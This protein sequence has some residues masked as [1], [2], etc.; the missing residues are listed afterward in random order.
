MCWAIRSLIETV[1]SVDKITDEFG[2]E[3]RGLVIIDTVTPQIATQTHAIAANLETIRSLT[4]ALQS[5][6]HSVIPQLDVFIH[7]LVDLAQAFDN[8]KNDDF[9]FLPPDALNTPDF[10]VGMD[11][12]MTADGKGA[13]IIVYHQGEAMS[14]EGIKQIQNV[15]TAAQESLKGTPLSN[16]KLSLAGASSNYRDIQDFSLQRPHHYDARDVWTGVPDRLGH[17]TGLSLAQSSCSSPWCYL[18]PGAW[19]WPL[20]FG[21]LSSGIKLHW[22]TIPISFIVLVGVGCD[23]NLLLLSRYREELHA[24]IR[25]GLIRAMAGS[26]KCGRHR[27]LRA[28]GHDA[29]ATFQRCNQYRPI[30]LNYLYWIDFRHADRAAILGDAARPA[31][32]PVVLV[33]AKD[34]KPPHF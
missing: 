24:G 22:L 31:A 20:W 4:L 2:N 28:G 13:R 16:A 9:F 25:T 21:R 19:D 32:R 7:P 6:L 17:H 1:D 14:P 11:F 27:G 34:S 33:A 23:Y 10:K 26:G 30:R 8:A 18:L 29:R 12:F 15:A 5:T 3:V